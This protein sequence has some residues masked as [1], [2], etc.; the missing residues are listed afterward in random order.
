M[1]IA[2]L[3][4]Q[5][6]FPIDLYERRPK[7]VAHAD[8]HAAAGKH[9]AIGL[10]REQRIARRATVTAAAGEELERAMHGDLGNDFIQVV[11]HTG[12]HP[13]LVEAGRHRSLRSAIIIAGCAR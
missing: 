3:A 6:A 2:Q 12:G 8:R 10:D 7:R 1:A 11:A 4:Q 5:G 13:K 9:I